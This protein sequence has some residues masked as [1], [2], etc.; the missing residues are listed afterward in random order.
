MG[1]V[2]R[3]RMDQRGITAV[4]FGLATIP[5]ILA[6]GGAVDYSRAAAE[7]T[8]LAAAIDAT[9]LALVR[10]PK[11]TSTAELARKAKAILGSTYLPTTG[12][13]LT[14]DPVVTRSADALTVSAAGSIENAFFK[15]MRQDRTAYDATATAAWGRQRIELA[16]VLDNTGSMNDTIGGQRKIDAL[17]NATKTLLADYRAAADSADAVK[18]SIVPFDTEVR[19]DPDVNR[20]KDWYRFLDPTTRRADWTGYVVDRFGSYAGTDTAITDQ[21]SKY[22]ALKETEYKTVPNMMALSRGDLPAIRPLTSIYDWNAYQGLVGMVDSMRPRGYTNIGLGVSW[23]VATLSS[24][25]PFTEASGPSSEVKRY[26]I[27]LTDGNDTAY[28]RDGVI[29][30]AETA[31]GAEADQIRSEMR[32]NTLKACTQAQG[33]A[34]VFT[35]RLL[36]GD[37]PLLTACASPPSA[38]FPEHYFDVQSPAQLSLVFK[39]ILG[40]ILKTRLTH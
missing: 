11:T 6:V 12:A 17:I 25:E 39:R 4:I 31:R 22:P 27:V 1:I 21:A 19:L 10:E 8:R 36:A 18:I 26:M 37:V 16:L 24:G 29:R 15:I 32:A 30:N 35:I 5:L 40:G 23:G 33:V 38:D 3:F 34:E 14:A 2:E 28:H 9:A 20:N 7:H 13:G